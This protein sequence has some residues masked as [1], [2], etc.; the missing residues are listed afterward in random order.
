MRQKTHT[1]TES[2]VYFPGIFNWHSKHNT[3][4][5]VLQKH[6]HGLPNGSQTKKCKNTPFGKTGQKENNE[7]LLCKADKVKCKTLHS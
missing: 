5:S 6:K 7:V 4:Y 2:I 3:K 1:Y